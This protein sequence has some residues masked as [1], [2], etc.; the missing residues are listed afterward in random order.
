M[1]PRTTKK[2]SK[3][4]FHKN[5]IHVAGK[6][7]RHQRRITLV[8][9]STPRKFLSNYRGHANLSPEYLDVNHVVPLNFI[10]NS[11]ISDVP[12]EF[13]TPFHQPLN[14]FNSIFL[15]ILHLVHTSFADYN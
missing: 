4:E 15:K 2:G 11:A 1:A 12:T 7:C 3:E 5:L 9:V 8:G 10:E 6:H 14:H 13:P